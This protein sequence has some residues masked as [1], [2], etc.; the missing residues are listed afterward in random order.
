MVRLEPFP[1][2]TGNQGVEPF[3]EAIGMVPEDAIA[4]PLEGLGGNV[5]QTLEPEI[6]DLPVRE[7]QV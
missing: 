1:P 5:L 3:G 4:N 7:S 6:R 2:K